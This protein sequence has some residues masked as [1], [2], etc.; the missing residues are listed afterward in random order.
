MR[1][2]KP[3]ERSLPAIAQM[4]RFAAAPERTAAREHARRG[5]RNIDG[6]VNTKI[7]TPGGL[8][9]GGQPSAFGDEAG[10]GGRGREVGEEVARDLRRIARLE[11]RGDREGVAFAAGMAERA[12]RDREP[13][14]ERGARGC[15]IRLGHG[16]QIDDEARAE[17]LVAAFIGDY[18]ARER[19]IREKGRLQVFGDLPAARA[20]EEE[21]RQGELEPALDARQRLVS[22]P[23]RPPGVQLGGPA[24]VRWRPPFRDARVVG[25]LL[26]PL[27]LYAGPATAR[28]D[29]RRRR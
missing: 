27:A 10:G 26:L 12:E 1:E 18:R 2:P 9:A 21:L 25:A 16:A 13:T 7:G 20:V 8:L 15:A 11:P 22:D 5:L 29:D 6:D 19:A 28:R 4:A 14:V 23:R 24:V 17:L 3:G